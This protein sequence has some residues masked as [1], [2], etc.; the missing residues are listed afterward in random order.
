MKINPI[1]S[2]PI[3]FGYSSIIKTSWKKGLMP[4]VKIGIYGGKLT[5]G[6]ITLEHIQPISK[7]GK[8][9]LNNLALATYQ[10]NTL[11]GSKPL[12]WFLDLDIFEKYLK[13]FEGIE[14]MGFNG[15]KYIE[16]LT[17]TVERI[18]K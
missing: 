10:N 7:G 4:S 8:T 14:I 1:Q 9:A 11:R 5:Q 6:N 2:N 18:F 17:K 16:A 12:K 13:Q 15:K 3:T